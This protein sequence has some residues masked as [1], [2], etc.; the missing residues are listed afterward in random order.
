MT[1]SASGTASRTRRRNS[2]MFSASWYVGVTMSG[3][4]GAR[5]YRLRGAS[6]APSVQVVEVEVRAHE[7]E[8]PGEHLRRLVGADLA[9]VVGL[10]PVAPDPVQDRDVGAGEVLVQAGVVGVGHARIHLDVVGRRIELRQHVVQV[11]VAVWRL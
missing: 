3:R 10:L 8:L 4:T 9:R 5:R 6:T 1:A 7:A 11:R 2:V